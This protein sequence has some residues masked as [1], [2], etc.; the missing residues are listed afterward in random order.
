MKIEFTIRD[1]VAGDAPAIHRLV[2]ELADYENLAHI[3][4]GTVERLNEHLFGER[5]FIE[6]MIAEVDRGGEPY[7]VAF[8]LYYHNYSTFLAKPG[9]FLEDLFVLPEYRRNGIGERLFRELASRAIERGC[10]RFE[11]AVLD[12]NKPALNFYRKLGASIMPDWRIC[13]ATG[14]SL[15]AMAA[16]D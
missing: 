7:P 11:W 12:W 4:T 5:P 1:A 16:N 13:R 6:A 3:C 9:L 14:E 15:R 8:A 2:R 10:G